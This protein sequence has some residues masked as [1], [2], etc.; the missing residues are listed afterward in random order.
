[1]STARSGSGPLRRRAAT[2]STAAGADS[3]ATDAHKT[4]NV[5]YDC[6]IAIVA[7]PPALRSAMGMHAS[8]LVPDETGPGDPFEKVPSCRAAREE[9]RCGRRSDPSAVRGDRPR[10]RARGQR[11][12]DRDGIAAID[13]AEVLNDVVFTQVCVAFGD[14]ERTREVTAR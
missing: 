3:W 7:D 1:M 4:L 12:R 13:G 9:C 6:G 14:D 5:P 8:Y 10:R 2:S 11:R